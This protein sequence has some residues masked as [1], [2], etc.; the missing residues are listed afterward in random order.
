MRARAAR[1]FKIEQSRVA[2]FCCSF[3]FYSFC[4]AVSTTI[5]EAVD[6]TGIPGGDFNGLT[7]AAVVNFMAFSIFQYV[8]GSCKRQWRGTCSRERLVH[9]SN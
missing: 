3:F 7:A 6:Y 9:R 5:R 8:R 2:A 4:A 1:A